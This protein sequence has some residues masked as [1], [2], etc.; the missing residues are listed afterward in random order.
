MNSRPRKKRYGLKSSTVLGSITDLNPYFSTGSRAIVPE[1]P[2]KKD[3]SEAIKRTD[4]GPISRIRTQIR[5]RS[6]PKK[7]TD[8]GSVLSF[9]STDPKKQGSVLRSAI[10]VRKKSMRSARTGT[11]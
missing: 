8:L 6:A 7:S 9:L 3:G 1:Y 10:K 2:Q 4:L 11:G 5:S